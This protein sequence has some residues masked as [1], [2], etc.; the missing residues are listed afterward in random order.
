MGPHS[1]LPHPADLGDNTVR[2]GRGQK[3]NTNGH[4]HKLLHHQETM[5]ATR[6]LGGPSAD[7]TEPRGG[8]ALPWGLLSLLC[9]SAVPRLLLPPS[10]SPGGL[11]L[12]QLWAAHLWQP[13]SSFT[14]LPLHSPPLATEPMRSAPC[15]Q[16][17]ISLH[18]RWNPGRVDGCLSIQPPSTAFPTHRE[19]CAMSDSKL[20]REAPALLSKSPI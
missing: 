19:P 14:A 13:M 8:P 18:E 10:S 15:G 16:A 11:L 7:G 17:M 2:R 1:S 20:S 5:E 4:F 9:R 12:V 3:Q 6:G